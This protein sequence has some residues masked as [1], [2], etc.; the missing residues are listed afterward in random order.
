MKQIIILILII[1]SFGLRAETKTFSTVTDALNY[2]GDR[3]AVTHLIITDSIKGNDYSDS[4]EWSRFRTLNETTFPSLHTVEIWTDQDIPN[5]HMVTNEY[6]LGLFSMDSMSIENGL[7]FYGSLW[8]KHFVATNTNRIGDM[9]FRNCK[10]LISLHIPFLETI[11]IGAFAWCESLT[12]IDFPFVKMIGNGGFAE[13][14]NLEFVELYSL[15]NADFHTFI[16]CKNLI[17]VN[18]G[19]GFTEP[20]NIKFG[21]AVFGSAEDFSIGQILTPNIKL[22][23]GKNVLPK[24]DTVFN[25]WQSTNDDENPIDYIWKK[26]NVTVGIEEEKKNHTVNIFPNPTKYFITVSIN[27]EKFCNLQVVLYNILGK[28]ILEIHNDFVDVGLFTKTVSIENLAKSVYFVKVFIDGK[29]ATLEK[30]IVD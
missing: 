10:N 18:F 29:Y 24:P 11:G 27:S 6:G 30:I 2:D 8:L 14:N 26:I 21:W 28:E 4:S 1:S 9:S 23:L 3:E 13:N 15:I 7:V 16:N 22:T 17:S 5:A 12:T 20:T 19:S 25:I